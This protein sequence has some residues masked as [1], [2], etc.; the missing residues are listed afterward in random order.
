MPTN[1]KTGKRIPITQAKEIANKFGYSQVIIH[2]Y[3]GETGMQCITTFGKSLADCKNAAEGGNAIKRLLKWDEELCNT[4]PNRVK[5][6]EIKSNKPKLVTFKD[7]D[8]KILAEFCEKISRQENCPAEFNEIVNK[9][10][11]EII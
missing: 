1:N 2:A 3:D 8:I 11:W 10:F 6:E 4:K 7:E 9:K 5:K